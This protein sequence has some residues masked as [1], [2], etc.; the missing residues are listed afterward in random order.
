M[1]AAAAAVAALT[2]AGCATGAPAGGSTTEK[3][4][5]KYAIWDE[6]QKPAMDKIIAAFHKD[7]PNVTVDLEITPNS[8]YGTKLQT[9]IAGGAGPDVFWMNGP[10]FQLY[11]SNGALAPLDDQGIDTSN[12][13]KG[14]VDLYTYDGKLYGAPKDF[15][16]IAVWYNKALFDAAGVAYP[17]A[18]W[19]WDDFNAAAAKLTDPAKGIYGTAAAP[20]S[21][22][23]YYNTIYQAGGE[24][25]STDHKKSGYDSPEALAGVKF[26]TDLI[27]SGES[28]TAQQMTDT[29][30]FD[31]WFAGKIA[32]FWDGSWAGGGYAKSA[33]GDK[34][35]VA[36][37]PA[38][39]TGNQS[40]IHG[41]ANAANAKSE[42]L[43]EAKEF[44]VFASGK[45]AAEIMAKTGT[46]IPAFNGQQQAWVDSLP[47]YHL[48]TFL[49][50]VATAVPYPVSKNTT[51]WNKHE[52]DIFAQMWAGTVTPEAGLKDLAA[53][54]QTE[55]DKE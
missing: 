1:V 12:Y 19:T 24:V 17:K 31:M 3:V 38:G 21:Q 39:K 49:D 45:E 26:W 25:I 30:P 55:L 48:S 53:K 11:A 43:A 46:V 36:P 33:V 22:M 27:A 5:L 2:L 6:N 47:Q 14:L 44:A 32:M 7:H 52:L 4:N 16:T 51:A 10:M 42:H 15:D 23:T 37:L 34:I 13:P 20:Y 50:E 54:M 40:V 35:D 28:P 29:S 18:G 8:D 41:L 9:A